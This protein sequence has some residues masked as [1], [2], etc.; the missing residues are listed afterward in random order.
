M[1]APGDELQQ[2]LAACR[3]GR[4]AEAERLC[5][6]IIDAAPGAYEANHLLAV[7]EA[8][9]GKLDMALAHFDRAL[10]LQSAAPQRHSKPGAASG[11]RVPPGYVI[12]LAR[13]ADR[14]ERFLRWNADKGVDLHIFDAVEGRQL[15]RQDL[16]DQGIIAEDLGFSA[17]ALGNAMSHRRL[18]ETCLELDRP[19]LIFED[20]AFL[21][22]DFAE[23]GERICLEVEQNCDLFY[24]GYNRDAILSIGYG[25]QWCNIAFAPPPAPF[26]A[27]LDRHTRAARGCSRSFVDARLVWGT[28]AYAVAPKGARAL[29]Q[30]CFP[31]SDKI[32]VRMYGSGRLLTPYALDGII[33]AAVQ[34][35]LVRA[36][37]AFPPIVIG[38]NEQSDSDVVRHMQGRTG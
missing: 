5:R 14:R 7:I 19:I 34:R 37:T 15:R 22:D 12:S 31:L 9:R 2:V 16:I 23:W 20:D 10:E 29:L 38:P 6:R 1:T 26:E 32:P 18:W 3:A 17:G 35:G 11:A 8:T 24:A 36:R 27:M 28:L 33:N 4:I 25:G 13:R 30:H 21:P